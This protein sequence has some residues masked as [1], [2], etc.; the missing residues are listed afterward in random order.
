MEYRVEGSLYRA[1]L[2]VISADDFEVGEPT[3]RTL[4]LYTWTSL[5]IGAV[6]GLLIRKRLRQ[7]LEIAGSGVLATMHEAPYRRRGWR[8]LLTTHLIGLWPDGADRGGT[9]PLSVKVGSGDGHLRPGPVTVVGQP[10]PGTHVLLRID[11]QTLWTTGTLKS[12][13]DPKATPT[14]R[15]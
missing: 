8:L 3:Y 6:A 2:T 5:P 1:T 12:G 10:T 9:P 15:S 7:E 4:W 11:G 13:I 14:R